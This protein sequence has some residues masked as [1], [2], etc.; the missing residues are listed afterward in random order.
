MGRLR[1]ETTPRSEHTTRKNSHRF[2]S[3]KST[4]ARSIYWLPA[5]SAA[6]RWSRPAGGFKAGENLLPV[7]IEHLASMNLRAL[8]LA[9]SRR[10][11]TPISVMQVKNRLG[12]DCSVC[13][14][15]LA[16]EISRGKHPQLQKTRVG[17]SMRTLAVPMRSRMGPISLTRPRAGDQVSIDRNLRFLAELELWNIVFVDIAHD[18]TRERS[19]MVKA[20]AEP[21]RPTPAPPHWSILRNNDSADWRI[22]IDD[23]TGVVL[24]TPRVFNCSSAAI[25]S[26]LRSSPC[27]PPVPAWLQIAPC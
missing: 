12:G 17:T 1:K 27:P 6:A 22:D 21:E 16:G 19:A 20:V 7:A 5:A 26:A 11:K 13:L 25:K 23:A 10:T 14:F 24:S 2:F 15:Y 9:G 4:S 3:A 18:Q 8:E